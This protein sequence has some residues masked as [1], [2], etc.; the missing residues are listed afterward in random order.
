[1][2]L[3]WSNSRY[4]NNRTA[5]K[6]SNMEI[7]AYGLS[8]SIEFGYNMQVDNCALTESN[9]DLFS[10]NAFLIMPI[11]LPMHVGAHWVLTHL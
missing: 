5:K 6:I 10:K 9:V 1:M 2:C 8:G 11:S 4:V 7:Y 3:I